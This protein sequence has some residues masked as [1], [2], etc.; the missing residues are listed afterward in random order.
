M[1][2]IEDI[3]G[4]RIRLLEMP[5]DP[6]P[7]PAGTTGTVTHASEVMGRTSL[8]VKWDIDRALTLVCPPDRYEVI[9][10]TTHVIFGGVD[11]SD[12]QPMFWNNDDGWGALSTATKFTGEE[13]ARFSHIPKYDSKSESVWVELPGA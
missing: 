3:V 5:K 12:G 4:R 6:C 7:I 11:E 8:T 10:Y 13:K 2:S 1:M 9:G